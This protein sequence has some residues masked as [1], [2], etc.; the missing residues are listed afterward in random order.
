MGYLSVS[1]NTLIESQNWVLWAGAAVFL[2]VC[3]LIGRLRR[4]ITLA[5]V[6]AQV[7]AAMDEIF[8]AWDR[9]GRVRVVNPVFSSLL[10][11]PES[12]VIGKPLAELS[13][14]FSAEIL[15]RLKDMES[16][17]QFGPAG[18]AVFLTRQSG[19]I[20][21]SATLAPLKDSGGRRVIGS[22]LTAR[23]ITATKRSQEA[24]Q[25]ERDFKETILKALGVAG[26]GAAIVDKDTLRFV[27]VND[28]LCRIYGFSKEQLLAAPSFLNFVAPEEVYFLRERL[29]RKMPEG[30]FPAY[31]DTIVE[32]KDG[33]K[34]TIEVIL[35]KFPWR[36]KANLMVAMIR[37]ITERVELLRARDARA[38][39]AIAE[40]EERYRTLTNH[41]P[42]PVFIASEGKFV[43]VNE[44]CARF[45]GA[46]GAQDLIGQEVTAFIGFEVKDWTNERLAQF[47][48]PGSGLRLMEFRCRRLNDAPCQAEILGLPAHYGGGPALQGIIKEMKDQGGSLQEGAPGFGFEPAA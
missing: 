42:Q 10:N 27:Y 19:R 46:S 18:D 13:F 16:K 25:N 31:Y 40:S 4:Q 11:W 5:G 35:E 39:A 15:Q 37:D 6:S 23:D 32:R 21:V 14:V 29:S 22:I 45:F 36:E 28:T 3:L 43:F 41:Y 8:V 48:A 2:A 1:L 20:D 7:A 38:Q 17:N 12:S 30:Q 47:M 44:A 34:I 33:K 24:F 9:G 26:Q